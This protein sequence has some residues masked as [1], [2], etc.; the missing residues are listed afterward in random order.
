M[1]NLEA[2][3]MITRK[4]SKM[5]SRM[6]VLYLPTTD[7]SRGEK[8]KLKPKNKDYYIIKKI[9]KM[10]NHLLVVIPKADW[11]YFRH[12]WDVYVE[13]VKR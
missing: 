5:G 8:V 3:K 1:A 11:G 2:V 4:V 6:R 10:G 9:S 13:K 7:F 12:R